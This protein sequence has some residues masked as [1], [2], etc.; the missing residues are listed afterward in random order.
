M[1]KH[2]AKIKI[3]RVCGK[4]KFLGQFYDNFKYE[5]KRSQ[6]KEC[7]DKANKI[8]KLRKKIQNLLDQEFEIRIKRIKLKME[9]LK[10]K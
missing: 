2:L 7:A 1:K 8:R 9:L 4:E 5:K 3:C 6:C 10:I